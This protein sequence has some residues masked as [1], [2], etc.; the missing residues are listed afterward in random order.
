[1]NDD[2]EKYDEKLALLSEED[3]YSIF[4]SGAFNIIS[5]GYMSLLIKVL[6]DAY[7]DDLEKMAA[8]DLIRS[9]IN[10]ARQIVLDE[11][12]AKSAV[13]AYYE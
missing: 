12:D 11:Y 3:K 7:R 2:F 4:D 1:M 9:D 13:E 10:Q 8:L 5:K 6:Q